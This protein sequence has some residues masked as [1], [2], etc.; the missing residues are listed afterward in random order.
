MGAVWMLLER[1]G[2]EGTGVVGEILAQPTSAKVSTTDA[3]P[4]AIAEQF[5]FDIVHRSD[6][7]LTAKPTERMGVG[8][9]PTNVM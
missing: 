5:G 9:Q 8:F 3:R 1:L 6:N 2:V 4:R 7:Q